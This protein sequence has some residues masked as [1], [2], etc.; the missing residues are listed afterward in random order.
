MDTNGKSYTI[1]RTTA[2]KRFY[3]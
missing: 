1:C 2:V 3:G